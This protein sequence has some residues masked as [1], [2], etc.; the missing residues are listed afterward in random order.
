MVATLYLLTVN[1]DMFHIARRM[2][3]SHM[4]NEF[5]LGP[6]AKNASAPMSVGNVYC[7]MSLLTGSA[8]A[9]GYLNYIQT[10][11]VTEFRKLAHGKLEY[12]DI[13]MVG[14]HFAFTTL[15]TGILWPATAIIMGTNA[16]NGRS[17]KIE[18]PR[19]IYSKSEDASISPS[20]PP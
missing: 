8:Y 2:C 5:T 13:P 12:G 6:R 10:S 18:N 11:H 4:P 14:L 7:I 19:P 16:Y 20:G 9:I 17:K 15:I 3:H 1:L